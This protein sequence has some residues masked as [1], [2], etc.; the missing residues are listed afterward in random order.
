MDDAIPEGRGADLAMLRFV[1][2]E[3]MICAGLVCFSHQFGLKLHQLIRHLMFKSRGRQV[4]A[5][6]FGSFTIG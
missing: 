2:V 6:A 4:S 1:D 3:V 5:F